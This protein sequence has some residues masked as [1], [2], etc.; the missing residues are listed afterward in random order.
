MLNL[1]DKHKYATQPIYHTKSHK[2]KAREHVVVSYREITKQHS[3]PSDRSYWTFCNKQPNVEGAEIVQLVRCGLIQKSQ[4]Y[5]VDYDIKNEGIIEFNRTEHPEANWFKGEWLDVIEN[6]YEIFNPALI[7]FDYTRTVV[8]IGCHLY[9][10]RTMNMCPAG[11]VV[12]VNLMLSDGHSSRRFDPNLLVENLDVHLRSP[13]DWNVFD[14]YRPYKSS[15]TEMATY[16]F[17]K[18]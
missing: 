17:W 1:I 7:Y 6:N 3:I 18:N 14:T 4:F 12:A 5:G 16:I 13:N 15:R 10:A 9:L 8:T 2:I 11:T